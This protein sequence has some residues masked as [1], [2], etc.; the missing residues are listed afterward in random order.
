M[1]T[2][3]FPKR[4]V[5]CNFFLFFAKIAG[6]ALDGRAMVCYDEIVPR[7]QPLW[8]VQPDTGPYF[9]GDRT[10]DDTIALLQNRVWYAEYVKIYAGGEI[11][12]KARFW[13]LLLVLAVLILPA[14]GER[15]LPPEQ[16]EGVLISPR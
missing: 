10:L 7:T 8:S 3:F 13:G 14:C 11:M 4:G 15:Q 2:K 12:K 5:P 1:S 16:E 9:A 6:N